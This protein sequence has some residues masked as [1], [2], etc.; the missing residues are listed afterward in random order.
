MDADSSYIL[1]LASVV[2]PQFKHL[3]FLDETQKITVHA[4]VV[5]KLKQYLMET[6]AQM[7][8]TD[9]TQEGPEPRPKKRAL[10]ILLGPEEQLNSTITPELEFQQYLSEVSASRD[11]NPINWW[12]ENCQRF[13][14]VSRL[15]AEILNIPAT[16]TASERTFSKAGLTVSSLRSCLKPKNVDA[17]VFLNKNWKGTKANRVT[18]AKTSE[19]ANRVRERGENYTCVTDERCGLPNGT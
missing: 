4:E 17:L 7:N 10:D 1:K 3:K 18:R 16:S 8:E 9:L 2:D 14:H 5:E 19:R 13:P 12:K 11:I 6:D 15:A